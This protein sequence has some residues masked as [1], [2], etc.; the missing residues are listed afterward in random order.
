[1]I[2]GSA[3]VPKPDVNVGVVHLVPRTQ[4]VMNAPFAVVEKF[5]RNIFSFRQKYCIK[6]VQ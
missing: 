2:A 4:P 6:G 1:L 3:F 5:M